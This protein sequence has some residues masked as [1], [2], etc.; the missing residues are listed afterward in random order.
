MDRQSLENLLRFRGYGQD[1]VVPDASVLTCGC[2]ASEIE[3]QAR[4]TQQCPNC[5]ASNVSILAEVKPLRDLY[6]LIQISRSQSYKEKRRRSSSKKSVRGAEECATSSPSHAVT[7]QTDSTDLLTLFHKFAK[8]EQLGGGGGGSGGTVKVQENTN[9]AVPMDIVAQKKQNPT[10]METQLTSSLPSSSSLNSASISPNQRRYGLESLSI[11]KTDFDTLLEHVSEQKEYNFSKCFPFHRKLISFPTQQ[12]KLNL[13][14][15]NPFKSASS[16]IKRAIS[17]SIISYLDF[18]RGVEVTRFA[19]VNEKRWELY[20]YVTPMR[21]ADTSRNI[22]PKLICCGRSTGEYGENAA[23]LKQPEIP[24]ARESVKRNDFNNPGGDDKSSG[25]DLRK[26]LSSWDQS[27]C[28]LTKSFLV[29]SGTKGLLRVLNVDPDSSLGVSPEVERGVGNSAGAGSQAEGYE[30]GEPIYTY[31]TDFP[32]RCFAIAPNESLIACGLTARERISDKEQ[33]F[34]V[35]H[36]MVKRGEEAPA[37]VRFIDPIT[38]TV[39]YRDPIKIIRFNASS[40][41]LICATVWES[42]YIIIKLKSERQS[43]YKKPRLIWTD[44]VFKASRRNQEGGG[45]GASYYG[46][47]SL[48]RADELMMTDEG[49]TD[50][51][52]ENTKPDAIV[53]AS[54]SLNLR[55]PLLIRLEG[56]KFNNSSQVAMD[57]DQYSAA[58]SFASSNG[59]ED[60]DADA[61]NITASE[62]MVRLPEVGSSIHRIAVS[63]RGDGIVFL[64]KDGKLFLVSLPGATMAAAST[65]SSSSSTKKVIVLLGEV[66]NAERFSEAASVRFSADG[67]RI[68]TLD[69]KGVFSVFDFTKG[70]PGEDLDV[71]KCKIISL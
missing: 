21:D 9:V 41:H 49:T 36:R 46:E 18:K 65:S 43:D 60:H 42:R 32:I 16:G 17:S 13:G 29:I 28:Q 34:I 50:I 33:P 38:I 64:D 2:L 23:N 62:V 37:R 51:Q 55:P 1:G 61:S 5:G 35:L 19:I 30:L 58:R 54:C 6:H 70:V 66:A 71:V 7:Q 24:G 3:F 15:I 31:L 27:F 26:R 14:A 47:E 10:S 44:V 52:F 20:E 48:S 45:G 56:A 57:F 63:P 68:F 12:M 69:R 59:I 25:V 40:S 11:N 4:D 22:K 39:P 53:I 8:E 67:G